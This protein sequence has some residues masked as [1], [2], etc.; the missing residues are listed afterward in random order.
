MGYKRRYPVTDL[1][2]VDRP[3][4]SEK[5]RVSMQ[6]SDAKKVRGRRRRCRSMI[7]NIES[8][9]RRFPVEDRP[10]CGYWHFHMPVAQ[11]FIDSPKTPHRIRRCCVQTV[12]DTA[13][14]LRELKPCTEA[15]TRVVAAI[16][17]P[18]VIDSQIIVFFGDT[19]Y[20]EFFCRDTDEQRWEPLPPNRSL[21]SEWTLNVPSDFRQRGYH[22]R[23]SDDDCVHEG[24][25]WF[26]GEI[27]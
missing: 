16:D 21:V 5:R 19:H 24:E 27:D 2:G 20:S 18:R 4:Q 11:S 22:E 12:L 6:Y 8:V 13:A 10:G 9:G 1:N 3:H 14:K 7:R 23:I 17:L 15:T 25:V 26:L